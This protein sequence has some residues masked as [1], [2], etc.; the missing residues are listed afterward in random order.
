[1]NANLIYKWLRDL[2]F[3][4]KTESTA[5][6]R[7]VDGLLRVEIED[8]EVVTVSTAPIVSVDAAQT[9]LRATR[10]DLTLSDGRR[11]FVRGTN[12][13]ACCDQ[14]GRRID[15]MIPAPSNTRVCADIWI[16]GSLNSTTT[17]PNGSCAASP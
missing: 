12:G 14:L 17:Q 7:A 8:A 13:V 5:D 3:S 4:R 15:C 11:V 16:T 9:P 10:V 2:R 6:L 1:V